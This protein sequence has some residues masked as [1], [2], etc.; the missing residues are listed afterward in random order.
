M[1]RWIFVKFGV[2]AAAEGQSQAALA[3]LIDR[4]DLSEI[5]RLLRDTDDDASADN[6]PTA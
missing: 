2:A 1:L 4:S 3:G 5:V 6:A